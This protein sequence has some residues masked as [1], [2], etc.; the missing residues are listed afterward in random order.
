MEAALVARAAGHPHK[1]PREEKDTSDGSPAAPVGT[2]HVAVT[3][4]LANAWAF[5]ASSVE[6]TFIVRAWAI[7]RNGSF[8][9]S[10]PSFDQSKS[11]FEAFMTRS[12]SERPIFPASGL[13]LSVMA[14]QN[15]LLTVS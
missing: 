7:S 11:F 9:R 5:F 12:D 2:H 14:S 6:S 8:G 15:F 1:S 10:L 3:P 4:S 13:N